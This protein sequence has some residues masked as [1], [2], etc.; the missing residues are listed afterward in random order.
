M[1]P[2]AFSFNG[3][4]IRWYGIFTAL[5][6]I[7]GYLTVRYRIRQYQVETPA[8][9]EHLVFWGLVGG[10]IGARFLYIIQYWQHFAGEPLEVFRVD[11]G[12]LVFQ[13]GLVG[14]F[15]LGLAV[16]RMKKLHIRTALDIFAPP[17]VLAHAIGRIGCFLNG[18]CFGKPYSGPL[19]VQYSAGSHAAYVQRQL[20]IIPDAATAVPVPIFPIQ[21]VAS[22]G[23]LVIF[24]VLL[25]LQKRLSA[26]GQLFALYV[27]LYSATRFSVEFGRGDY[28]E[29]TAG[30]TPAQV[31]G[32][33]LFP[34]ALIGFIQLRRAS[35]SGSRRV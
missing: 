7:T 24:L 21:L 34:A 19:A 9:Y 8:A 1:D 23:N 27:M 11:H 31:V 16:A 30:L 29:F 3:L 32:L 2:V 26:R 33:F 25:L 22:A 5:A 15:M 6:F 13:G 20:G 28:L 18:C 4:E 14:A 17:L 35:K 10:I 12:G